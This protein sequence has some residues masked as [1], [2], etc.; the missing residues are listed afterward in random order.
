MSDRPLVVKATAQACDLL[1]VA[2]DMRQ[3]TSVEKD[4]EE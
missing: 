4:A 1:M 2:F 3:M